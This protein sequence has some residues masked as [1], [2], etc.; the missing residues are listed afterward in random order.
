MPSG[1]SL[2]NFVNSSFLF[3]PSLATVPDRIMEVYEFGKFHLDV[4]ERTLERGPQRDSIL[5]PEKRSRHSSIS[6]ET[7]AYSS[8]GRRF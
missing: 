4:S 1:T 6:S 5:I 2:S 3:I 7:A 8:R